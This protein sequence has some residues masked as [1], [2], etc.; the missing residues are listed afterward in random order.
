MRK[1][2]MNKGFEQ[3]VDVAKIKKSIK[4]ATMNDLD[5]IDVSSIGVPK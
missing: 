4:L 1:L 3:E 5:C 2:K